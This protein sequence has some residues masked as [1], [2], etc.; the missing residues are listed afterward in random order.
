[1]DLPVD[2]TRLAVVLIAVRE[3][4]ADAREYW[5]ATEDVAEKD[6]AV[7]LGRHTTALRKALEGWIA[8]RAM[9]AQLADKSAIARKVG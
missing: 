7:I 1:M 4:E 6:S 3:L 8:R 9:R 2:D 5:L